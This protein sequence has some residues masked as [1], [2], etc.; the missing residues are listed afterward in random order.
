MMQCQTDGFAIL[1]AG[2]ICC[3]VWFLFP[4]SELSQRDGEKMKRDQAEI[5]AIVSHPGNRSH[6]ERNV[7]K[8]K[9]LTKVGYF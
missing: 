8:A 5:S 9:Q 4:P 6:S 2:N 1:P 7:I 3:C